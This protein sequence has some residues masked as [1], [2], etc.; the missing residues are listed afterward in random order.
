MHRLYIAVRGQGQIGQAFHMAFLGRL[1]IATVSKIGNGI[2]ACAAIASALVGLEATH[3]LGDNLGYVEDNTLPSVIALDK[4]AN[5]TSIAQLTMDKAMAA[6][7][8]ATRH[9]AMVDFAQIQ[10]EVDRLLQAYP[11]LLSDELERKQF[12]RVTSLWMAY[13]SGATAILQRERREASHGALSADLDQIGPQLS[14]ALDVEVRHNQGIA[15]R[16]GIDGKA[17]V[18]RANAL[19]VVL[20][21]SSILAALGV[22][23]LFLHRVIWPLSRL[24]VA[25]DEMAGGNLD[26]AVPGHDL[27]DEVGDI[28]RALTAIKTG[29]ATRSEQDAQV[30][31]A[32]QKQVVSVLGEGL[33]ALQAG[34]LTGSIEQPFPGEYEALRQDFNE[35]LMTMARMISKVAG[36]AQSVQVGATEIASQAQDLARRTQQQG[37]SLEKT[38][39]I[40]RDLTQSVTGASRDAGEAAK[41]AQAAHTNAGEGGTVMDHAVAA[42][43]Q[44]AQSS[45]RMKEIVGL[46]D[47]IAFQTNLLALNAGVEAARAGQA[48]A[49]FAVVANEVRA[50]SHRSAKAAKD[51]TDIIQASGRD[52]AS[53]VEMISRTRSALSQILS[54]TA[55]LAA[56]IEGIAAASSKQATSIVQVEATVRDLDRIT[57]QNATLVQESTAA[58]QSLAHES[59]IMEH[60][61]SQFELGEVSESEDAFRRRLKA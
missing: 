13:K 47:G 25:M 40:V 30:Q 6:P 16:A 52:V 61:V 28:G 55:G 15:A 44:I 19:G 8:D 37:A 50:L 59:G 36:V 32:M 42:M 33:A 5:R 41:L 38:S 18:G 51:I 17:A 22:L 21:I 3:R 14:Q 56:R 48:G 20:M 34:R 7:D 31:I 39:V 49:G 27:R 11:P 29:V 2:L 9:K 54:D 1:R 57:Q 46:I 58:A 43:N 26:R 23:L 12:S 35:A 4:I 60:L 45:H 10:Q 53:G 24:A